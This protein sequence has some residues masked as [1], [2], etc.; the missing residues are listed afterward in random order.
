M[1]YSDTSF[2]SGEYP[3]IVL[4]WWRVYKERSSYLIVFGGLWGVLLFCFHVFYWLSSQLV[5]YFSPS[6]CFIKPEREIKKL[7]SHL[8]W[9]FNWKWVEFGP[10]FF[11]NTQNTKVEPFSLRKILQSW[12][13]RIK[14]CIQLS[15]P[16]NTFAV[17]I[18]FLLHIVNYIHI[19]CINRYQCKAFFPREECAV[20][21]CTPS[22]SSES[23][24]AHSLLVELLLQILQGWGG[25]H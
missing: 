13:A 5:D 10:L 21:S 1:K 20:H 17:E 12:G 19:E 14:L 2:I 22:P 23:S 25:G 9:R 15:S 6:N 4:L 11:P 3:C 18:F 24:G 16:F 8:V 7:S